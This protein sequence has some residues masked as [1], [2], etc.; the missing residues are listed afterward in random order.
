MTVFMSM[1]GLVVFVISAPFKGF[2]PA[3]KRMMA[4]AFAGLVFDS[5]MIALVMLSVFVSSR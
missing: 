5:L 3:F 2:K 4:M 1:V